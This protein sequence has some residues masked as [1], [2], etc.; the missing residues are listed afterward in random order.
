MPVSLY[1][2]H[3]ERWK[4]CG[5]CSLCDRRTRVVLY[6]GKVPCDVLFVGEAPGESEDVVGVPFV[7]PAGKLLDSMIQDAF[8]RLTFC[9]MCRRSGRFEKQY[10]DG[11]GRYECDR[12]HLTGEGQPIRVGYTNLVGCIP[13][14][15][16]GAKI[17]EP[18]DESIRACS[19]RLQEIVA[20][21]KPRLI[22]QVGRLAE[23]WLTPGFKTTI[24]LPPVKFVK[25][26]HPAA[27]LRARIDQQ[28]FAKQQCVVTLRNA[29]NDLN[30][31]I[32]IP[33]PPITKKTVLS[34]SSG[35][36]SPPPAQYNEGD[37][38]Y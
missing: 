3:V 15:E 32:Q 29:V 24:A 12:K 30:E 27:I 37:I 13:R 8:G 2:S 10:T 7:G 11:K 1:S 38:P 31:P 28:G 23:T 20:I 17:G 18:E 6:R 16:D 36:K 4:D 34:K 22:V 25:V 21:A 14:G 26:T 33:S 19:G 9:A 5:G 35:G